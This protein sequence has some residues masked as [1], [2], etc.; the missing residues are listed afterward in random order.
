LCA[1]PYSVADA[2]RQ[3]LT[4][5]TL[6]KDSVTLDAMQVAMLEAR[7]PSLASRWWRR[8]CLWHH[9]L[10]GESSLMWA[11]LGYLIFTIFVCWAFGL[12][13]GQ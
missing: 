2:A 13:G 10:W 6:S 12:F 3:A 8:L 11:V 5:V 1:S 9:A 7:R 4:S